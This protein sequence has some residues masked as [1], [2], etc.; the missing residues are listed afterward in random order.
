VRVERA[1]RPVA[2]GFLPRPRAADRVGDQV[3]ERLEIRLSA[4]GGGR[5]EGHR[6][7]DAGGGAGAPPL[8]L[9]QRGRIDRRRRRPG[10]AVER[11]G[12]GLHLHVERVAQGLRIALAQRP[13]DA[14]AVRREVRNRLDEVADLIGHAVD[15]A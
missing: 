12:R 2:A 15:H 1:D 11:V 6:R 14:Q 5:A 9:G 7:H 13:L 10:R 8:N 3:D 4:A